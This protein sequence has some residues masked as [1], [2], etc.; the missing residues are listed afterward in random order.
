MKSHTAKTNQLNELADRVISTSDEQLA[1]EAAMDDAE[2]AAWNAGSVTPEAPEGEDPI[3]A[4]KGEKAPVAAKIFKI[5]ESKVDP[6]LL[7][8]FEALASRAV[9]EE[10]TATRAI[11]MVLEAHPSATRVAIKH[12]AALV[13]INPLTARNT[14]DKFSKAAK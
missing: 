8:L 11:Q 14:F 5:V 13:G 7:T 1:K 9:A 3:E 2:I 12:T 6:V 4:T 10:I